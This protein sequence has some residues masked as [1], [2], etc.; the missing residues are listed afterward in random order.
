MI[1]IHF[2][3]QLKSPYLNHTAISRTDPKESLPC[4]E[5]TYFSRATSMLNS[6]EIQIEDVDYI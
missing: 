2:A 5:L 1:R 4:Y 6:T 3:L